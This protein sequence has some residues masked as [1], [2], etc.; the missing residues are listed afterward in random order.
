MG[1]PRGSTPGPPPTVQTFN[2]LRYQVTAMFLVTMC[3]TLYLKF[4]YVLMERGVGPGLSPDPWFHYKT[5]DHIYIGP[6]LLA[7]A[8]YS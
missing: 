1:S 3:K 5:Y 2:K 4:T 7:R 8:L 6:E